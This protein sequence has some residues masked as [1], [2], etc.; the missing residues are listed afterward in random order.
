MSDHSNYNMT[1]NP[2]G[3]DPYAHKANHD[4]NQQKLHTEGAQ[5]F[6]RQISNLL[7]TLAII[8]AVIVV[9]RF[10]F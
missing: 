5:G 2:Q 4:A 7:I 3:N 9:L 1:P 8:A 6:W 10:I